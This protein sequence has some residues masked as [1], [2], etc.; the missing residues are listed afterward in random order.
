VDIAFAAGAA[1][2]TLALV[3]AW[4]GGARRLGATR[5]LLIG[6][7]GG[8]ALLAAL[9]LCYVYRPRWIPILSAEV[10]GER[11]EFGFER[12]WRP[13]RSPPVL[14]MNVPLGVALTELIAETGLPVIGHHHDF[15]WERARF[16]PN[17]AGDYLRKSF[18]PTLPSLQHVVINSLAAD[19][20]ALRTGASPTLIP[21]VMDFDSPPAPDGYAR[22]LRAKLEIE[23]H[24]RLLLQPTRIVPRK[25][26][27]RSIELARR[28][29]Q[30]CTL[31]ISHASGDEGPQYK[32]YLEDY[33]ALLGVPVV[34]AGDV[35]APRRGQTEDGT[36]TYAL[37]DIYS[38]AE[39]VTYPSLIE[40]F[41]NAF[42]EAV[43]HRCPVVLNRYEVFRRD[44][45]PKGFKTVAFDGFVGED[46]VR[47]AAELLR[48]G[49]LRS[50][51]VDHNFELGRRHY[52]YATLEQRL[53][54]LLIVCCRG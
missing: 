23:P 18:P 37:G 34:F 16:W 53:R 25:G 14:P 10:E 45:E 46:T 42:L 17:C 31:V 5:T 51:V 30:D 2:L 15:A 29:G 6:V 38:Q 4:I 44:I 24:E 28:L 43:Y 12:H 9:A 39:L 41:G 40:G 32:Q 48:D 11:I 52:S 49:E 27:E 33:A 3:A 36:R 20:L 50:E 1:V 8:A 47:G 19:Q 22:D 21:N 26:I 35:F 54:A 7:P 13:W